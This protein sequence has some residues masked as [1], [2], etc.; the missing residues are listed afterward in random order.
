MPENMVFLLDISLHLL[1]TTPKMSPSYLAYT[2]LED[3]GSA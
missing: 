3:S 2:Y 1:S